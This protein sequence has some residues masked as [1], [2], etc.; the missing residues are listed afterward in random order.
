MHRHTEK[1][2]YSVGFILLGVWQLSVDFFCFM[3]S[4]EAVLAWAHTWRP[5]EDCDLCRNAQWKIWEVWVAEDMETT[6]SLYVIE[7]GEAFRSCTLKERSSHREHMDSVNQH[8]V[9][10]GGVK[11]VLSSMHGSTVHVPGIR[12]LCVVPEAVFFLNSY[13]WMKPF[14]KNPSFQTPWCLCKISHAFIEDI[15]ARCHERSWRDHCE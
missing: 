7:K 6:A 14:P 2:T 5:L 9:F 1:P 13:S 12:T 11:S 8:L 3:V 4:S 10:Q 15:S